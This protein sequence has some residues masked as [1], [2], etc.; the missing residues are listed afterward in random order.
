[1]DEPENAKI[2][3]SIGL[4]L[5]DI[6]DFRIDPS[7]DLIAFLFLPFAELAYPELLTMSSQQPH[8]LAAHPHLTFP[9]YSDPG[10]RDSFQIVDDIIGMRFCRRVQEST[11]NSGFREV[12]SSDARV[13]KLA[14]VKHP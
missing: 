10:M 1:V 7:Q 4:D 3:R 5:Q 6:Q 2:I 9:S 14:S 13:M 8:P 12:S 11:Q